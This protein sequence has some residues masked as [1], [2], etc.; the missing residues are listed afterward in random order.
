[1]GDSTDGPSTAAQR[2]PE[3]DPDP[4]P[5]QGRTGRSLIDRLIPWRR[6][7]APTPATA[8]SAMAEVSDAGTRAIVTNL[9]KLRDRRVADIAVPRA[10]IVAVPRDATLEEVMDAYRESTLTR[11]PVFNDSLDDPTGFLHLKDVVLN[12]TG[13]STPFDVAKLSRRILYVP[14][15]MPVAALLQRMQN[16]RIHIALVIDEYG[17]VDGL[18][19]IEDVLEQIVGEIEDEHDEEETIAWREEAPGVYLVNARAELDE[20]EAVAKVDLLADDVDEEVDTPGG[21]V[22]K[23][24]GRIPERAEVVPHPQGHEF[25]IVDADPRRIKRLRVRLRRDRPEMKAAAE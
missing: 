9:H 13:D 24:L 8:Q 17:G 18:V 4:S 5:G 10:D 14:P 23:L 25:E 16:T 15:S 7:P 20:F 6:T 12:Q 3:T 11:L 2:A 1:M 22:F 19:T 21:L